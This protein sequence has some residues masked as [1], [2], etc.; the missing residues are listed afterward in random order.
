MIVHIEFQDSA[1]DNEL[2]ALEQLGT[3][4]SIS[5]VTAFLDEEQ[6]NFS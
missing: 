3:N 6:R 5:I 4:K 1:N 2:E